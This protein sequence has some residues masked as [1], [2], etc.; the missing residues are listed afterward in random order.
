MVE[1]CRT[2]V[3]VK[4]WDHKLDCKT[5]D[6]REKSGDTQSTASEIALARGWCEL[7]CSTWSSKLYPKISTVRFRSNF[8]AHLH[9][10]H[11]IHVHTCRPAHASVFLYTLIIHY[12]YYSLHSSPRNALFGALSVHGHFCNRYAF[13]CAAAVVVHCSVIVWPA[14]NAFIFVSL[15]P[16][17]KKTPF[18]S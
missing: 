10:Q 7:N 3:N 13:W 6:G 17:T 8:F 15:I 11:D 16:W 4:S 14:L 5:A 12:I 2:T 1:V 9:L 18:R